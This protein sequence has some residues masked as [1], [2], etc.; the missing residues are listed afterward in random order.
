MA[1]TSQRPAHGDPDT[2]AYFDDHTHEYSVGRLRRAVEFIRQHRT[3]DATLVDIGCG[4]GNVLAHIKRHTDLHAVVG[5]DVSERS[6]QITREQVGA[7]VHLASVLDDSTVERFGERFDFAIMAAVLHH[8][9][10]PTRRRSLHTAFHGVHNAV[11]LVRPG[12]YLIVIEPTFTPSAPLTAL[13]WTKTLLSKLFHRRLALG[14][15]WNNVGAPVVSYY[16]RDHVLAMVRAQPIA[17]VVLED[18]A[19]QPLSRLAAQVVTKSNTTV[20]AQRTGS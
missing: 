1:R 20:V 2:A 8:L 9:V 19:P 4:T 3:P 15:Y 6:L 16:S 13:F 11:R 5:L 18:N 17:R 14:S 7:E 12:G 10:E